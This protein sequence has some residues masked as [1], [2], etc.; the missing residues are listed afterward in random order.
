MV[1]KGG[2]GKNNL[3]HKGSPALELCNQFSWSRLLLYLQHRCLPCWAVPERLWWVIAWQLR[4][5]PIGE[6]QCIR[7]ARLDVQLAVQL[8]VTVPRESASYL[9]CSDGSGSR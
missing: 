3:C 4:R 7:C 6:L 5:V 1:K 8:V 2:G 9:V